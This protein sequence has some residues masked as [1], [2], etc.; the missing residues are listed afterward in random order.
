MHTNGSQTERHCHKGETHEGDQADSNFTNLLD[1]ALCCAIVPR[2]DDPVASPPY[3][4]DTTH[5]LPKIKH[6]DGELS[7]ESNEPSEWQQENCQA[8]HVDVSRTLEQLPVTLWKRLPIPSY[9]PLCNISSNRRDTLKE[10][11]RTPIQINMTMTLME[12]MNDASAVNCILDEFET[13]T[14]GI[15]YSQPSRYS[16]RVLNI[17]SGGCSCLYA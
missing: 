9:A 10:M 7:H 8:D 4:E 17:K 15:R 12:L 2:R 6:E 13:T 16:P 14:D 1:D 3:I 11:E 5:G